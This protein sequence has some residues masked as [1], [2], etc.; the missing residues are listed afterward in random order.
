ML[1]SWR[2]G[3]YSIPKS[4]GKSKFSLIAALGYVYTKGR[5]EVYF[6]MIRQYNTNWIFLM[7][8]YNLLL[9]IMKKQRIVSILERGRESA[10]YKRKMQ[11]DE[12]GIVRNW[13]VHLWWHAFKY[14]QQA[15]IS[16]ML[17]TNLECLLDFKDFLQRYQCDCAAIIDIIRV[18]LRM[19][20]AYTQSIIGIYRAL[21]IV[22]IT[23]L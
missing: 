21:L 18:H 13:L 22:S 17:Y 1:W 10:C 11:D 5:S 6:R 14:G 15:M 23:E 8:I 4:N 7:I 12:Q 19:Y 16:G 9:K 20:N 2:G 3:A